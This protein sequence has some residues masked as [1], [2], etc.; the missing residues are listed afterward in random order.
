MRIYACPTCNATAYFANRQCTCGSPLVYDPEQDRFVAGAQGCANRARIGCNWR[1][2]SPD[3]G[4]CRSCAMTEV[5]PDIKQGANLTLWTRA[6][7]SNRWVLATLGRW[8][9]FTDADTGSPPRFHLLSEVTAKGR[10]NVVMGHQNGL[11]TINLAEADPIEEIRRREALSERLR[12]MT[13]HFRHEIAHFLFERLAASRP[14]FL[15]QF[16]QVFGDPQADYGAALKR[17]Y[18]NGAPADWNSRFISPYASAHA[19]ED[20]AETS[21][22]VMHLTDMLDSAVEA[23]LTLPMLNNLKYDAYAETDARA[24]IK[25]AAAYGLA[26]NHVNRS[27]GHHDI[28]PFVHS[29]VVLDKMVKAH[30]WLCGAGA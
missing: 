22:H 30:G 8:G 26:L 1:V 12:T 4:L 7:A 25:T 17:H 21:A 9:W 15:S 11:V 10:A 2:E 3:T 20:W 6:E 27:I 23:G 28:Y 13:G 5:V 19:H 16:T 14:G 29:P 18:A 24:L